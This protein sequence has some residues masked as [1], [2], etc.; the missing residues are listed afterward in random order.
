M[1]WT[2]SHTDSLVDGG[3]ERRRRQI[4]QRDE[5]PIM[6]PSEVGRVSDWIQEAC[7]SHLPLAMVVAITAVIKEKDIVK[8]SLKEDRV[9]FLSQFTRK[10]RPK[11]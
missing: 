1:G 5:R 3:T 6:R 10:K 8:Q 11:T 9:C 4:P 2:K 7:W